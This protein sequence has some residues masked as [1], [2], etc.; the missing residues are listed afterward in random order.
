MKKIVLALIFF[1]SSISLAAANPISDVD[2]YD[3]REDLKADLMERYESSYSTVNMLLK[4]G[5]KNYDKL[6]AID[7][8]EVNNKILRDLKERYYPSFST[9][10][11]LYKSNIKAYNEL[12]D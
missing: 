8:N 10:F 5:M 4:S 6:C 11:M 1:V 2:R 12:N 7:D 3:A 9:I